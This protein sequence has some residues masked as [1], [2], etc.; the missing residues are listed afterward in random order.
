MLLR[1]FRRP[2]AVEIARHLRN[3]IFHELRSGAMIVKQGPRPLTRLFPDLMAR[4]S[5]IRSNRSS[6][7]I[8]VSVPPNKYSP[9][10]CHMAPYPS[11]K[12]DLETEIGNHI[13]ARR[14]C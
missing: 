5:H 9:C 4:Q 12:K 11:S 10:A 2:N 13:R 3:G 7:L 6:R 8:H 14:R 1:G